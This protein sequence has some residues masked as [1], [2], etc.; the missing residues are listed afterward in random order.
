MWLAG[1]LLAEHA[2]S[3]GSPV[4]CKPGMVGHAC[5]PRYSG[6]GRLDDHNKF[7]AN[8]AYMIPCLKRRTIKI[9]GGAPH[10]GHG[11]PARGQV[12]CLCDSLLW[13]PSPTLGKRLEGSWLQ[14]TQLT[15]WRQGLP[16]RGVAASET[17]E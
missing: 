4:P 1:K 12:V 9:Q 14:V 2:Q 13:V 8:L 5:D 16:S 6:D 17:A 15:G 11:V 7:G 10:T 3:P